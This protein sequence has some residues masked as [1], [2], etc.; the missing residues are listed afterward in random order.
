MLFYL[1]DI[2]GPR[3]T[4]LRTRRLLLLYAV[5]GLSLAMLL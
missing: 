3:V 5:S 4:T 1:D 2:P